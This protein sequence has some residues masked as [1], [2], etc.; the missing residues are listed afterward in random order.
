MQIALRGKHVLLLL[1]SITTGRSLATILESVHYYGATVSGA[2]AIFS[3][4]DG[5]RGIKVAAALH[6][7]DVPD[8]ESYQTSECPLCKQKLPIDALVLSFCYSLL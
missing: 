7:S 6:A 3:A 5:A 2:C 1:G 4:V 8:Y